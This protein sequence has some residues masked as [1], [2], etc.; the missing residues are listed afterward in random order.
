[1]LLVQTTNLSSIKIETK[2]SRGV[3]CCCLRLQGIGARAA[4]SLVGALR[5]P[6][7]PLDKH[8]LPS[9]NFSSWVFDPFTHDVWA[10]DLTRHRHH[11]DRRAP[12]YRPFHRHHKL[13]GWRLDWCGIDRRH[14]QKR[15]RGSGRT[16]LRMRTRVW[17]VHTPNSHR[18]GYS[19]TSAG[20]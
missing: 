8:P 7:S 18:F 10:R 16:L 9:L 15:W 13:R 11:P 19:A 1:M 17:H 12:G 14:W 2:D 4:D 5:P 6:S 20:E 3:I